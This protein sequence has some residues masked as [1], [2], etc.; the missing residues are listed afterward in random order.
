MPFQ[1]VVVIIYSNREDKY[2]ND[3]LVTK[4]TNIINIHSNLSILKHI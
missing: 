2:V 4:S 1:K 3:L